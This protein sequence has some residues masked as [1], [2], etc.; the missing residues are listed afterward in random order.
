MERFFVN[1]EI[2]I[3]KNKFKLILK[4]QH[5]TWETNLTKIKLNL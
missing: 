3:S 5:L 4:S 1:F 2:A